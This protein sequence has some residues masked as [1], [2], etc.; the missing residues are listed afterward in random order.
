MAAIEGLMNEGALI[1]KLVAWAEH[2]A[3]RPQHSAVALRRSIPPSDLRSAIASREI[4]APP[5]PSLVGSIS[6]LPYAAGAFLTL[7]AP[8]SI[9]VGVLL[10]TANLSLMAAKSTFTGESS[11][12]LGYSTNG[13][14]TGLGFDYWESIAK[15]SINHVVASQTKAVLCALRLDF[16]QRVV[17]YQARLDCPAA[18][19]DLAGQ[20]HAF[21]VTEQ[22]LRRLNQALQEIDEGSSV[23]HSATLETIGCTNGGA[24]SVG[25]GGT[26]DEGVE[27][28]D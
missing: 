4:I 14:V 23:R 6:A 12:G 22:L 18:A 27:P 16:S 24:G 17:T 15:D 3:N 20:I 10:G 28:G 5:P 26:D 1:A 11:W 2:S 9:P 8:L 25:A 21:D 7:T 13:E 19:G